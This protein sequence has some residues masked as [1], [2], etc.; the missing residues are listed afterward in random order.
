[1]GDFLKIFV[2]SGS[3][4][5]FIESNFW[6]EIYVR[7]IPNYFYLTLLGIHGQEHIFYRTFEY[8]FTFFRRS[9]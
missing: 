6:L 7:Y 3:T 4:E 2:I 8:Y 9:G 5:I 1:M